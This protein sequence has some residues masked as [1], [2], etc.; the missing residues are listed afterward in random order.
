[1]QN[2]LA[3]I[4]L[5]AIASPAYAGDVIEYAT[6][7]SVKPRWENVSVN[8]PVTK[9]KD[10]EVPIYSMQ[11]LHSDGATGGDVLTGMIIGGLLGKGITG[12]DNGAAAGAVFGG[13]IAADKG[14]GS[15]RVITGYSLERRCTNIDRYETQERIKNFRISYELDG[16]YG[17]SYTYNRYRVGDRIPVSIS[18]QAN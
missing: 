3:S 1:M 8:I 7:T 2:F 14:Q 16:T 11:Q 17:Q 4:A 13:V 10:V 5:V 12:K 6:V 15:E 18:I 9:C